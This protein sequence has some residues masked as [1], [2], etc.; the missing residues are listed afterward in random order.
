MSNMSD[1]TAVDDGAR[2]QGL[3]TRLASRR[4]AVDGPNVLPVPPRPSTWTQLIRQFVGFFAVMLWVAAGLALIAGLPQLGGAI[5]I[6]VIIN[7]VFSFFQEHRAERAAD[8]LA[9]LL[10][11]RTSVV[12]D[13]ARTEIDA[14]E[15]V[16]GDLVILEAG[17][18][19]SADLTVERSNILTVD[20][21]MI[22]GESIP[23]HVSRG[24]HLDAGMFVVSGDARGLVTATG[25]ATRL[26]AIAMSTRAGQRPKSPLQIELHRVVRV[27]A[28]VAVGVGITFFGLSLLIGTSPTEGL[29]FSVGV[30]VALVP[31]AMLPTVTLSL[32][33]GAEQLAH[34]DALVRRLESVETLGS[35]TFICTDKTGT[36]TMNQMTVVELWTP[37]GTARFDTPGYGPVS[38]VISDVTNDAA[39]HVALI[40]SRCSTAEVVDVDGEWTPRGD[41]MEAALVAMAHRLEVDVETDRSLHP[42]RR[43]FAFDPH[44]RRM[45]VEVEG[46]LAVKGAPDSV[47]P[48]CGTGSAGAQQALSTMTSRGLRVIAVAQKPIPGTLPDD[49]DAVETDLEFL[50]LVGIEDPPRPGVTDA[51]A[52]CRKAGIRVA[53]ITGDHP[54][55]AR[56][57]ATQ[58][59]LLG[60]GSTVLTGAELPHDDEHLADVVDHDGMVL[61]RIDPEDKFR[62]TKALQSRGHVV[63][64]TGDGVNDG[65][66]LQEA[67][68]GIAMGRTGTDVARE[69]ADLVLLRED[70]GVIVAAVEQGRATFTNIRRF[71]TYHLTDNVAELFPFVAWALSNGRFPLMIGVLQVLSL[72][73]ATD[74][75]PALALGAEPP[76]PHLMDDPPQRGHLL[77][78]TVAKRAFGILGPTE[79]ALSVVAFLATYW[80]AGWRP[81]AGFDLGSEIQMKA[82]GAAWATIVIAQLANAFACRSA[83]RP[84]WR[85]GWTS[86]RLL[87]GAIAIELMITGSLLFIRPLATT[88]HQ[89]PPGAIGWFVAVA[90]I[91][92]LLGVDAVDKAFRNRWRRLS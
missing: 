67:D 46:V 88:L 83:T 26:A 44:R 55:T 19:I 34:R 79:V 89:A 59:G 3:S 28:S 73:I 13:G 87:L 32:A 76:T 64:M 71:L 74:T 4:L 84:A 65:P 45:S 82:S 9:D 66:A 78:R 40:A 68:I 90:G 47:I 20:T 62:I 15:L 51:I 39:R 77:D 18:M 38:T 12:R 58:I 61:A 6:V 70:F 81:G 11:R 24:D 31:E 86:N 57:I 30:A 42:P 37:H 60:P 85:L 92:V 48:L 23:T 5:V 25:S 52:A 1:A 80:V 56:A 36:I 7:G 72:D 29:V 69:A 50:G 43:I 53:M 22:T 16:V 63:A 49:P 54:A 8:H 41:T 35:V 75:L 27:I 21:S 14:T 17:D 91:A 33:L 2:G 10:P